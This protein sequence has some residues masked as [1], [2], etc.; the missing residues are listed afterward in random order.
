MRFL[1]TIIHCPLDQVKIGSAI[2]RISSNNRDQQP[3]IK[4]KKNEKTKEQKTK[5]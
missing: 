2:G 4:R 3:H 5:T 1:G